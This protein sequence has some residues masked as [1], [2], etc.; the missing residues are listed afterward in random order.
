M[1][2]VLSG[3]SCVSIW[4]NDAYVSNDLDMIIRGMATR[5][6]IVR[7]LG[8]LGFNPSEKGGRYFTHPDTTLSLEFPAGPLMVGD[9][10]V[11]DVATIKTDHG[12]LKLLTPTDCVKDRLAGYLHWGDE[13]NFQQA[14]YVA[15]KQPVDWNSIA[16]WL[17]AEGS[18]GALEK[19]KEAVES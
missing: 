5:S 6:R 15:Q 19:L 11:T 17:T 16:E 3:G 9:E 2:A 7:A 10:H 14:V 4:S 13:Q 18:P 8:A 12:S 1:D